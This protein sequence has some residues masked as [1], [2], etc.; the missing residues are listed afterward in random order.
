MKYISDNSLKK[1]VSK[2]GL[3]TGKFGTIIPDDFAFEMLD[4]FIDYGGTVIDTARNYYEWVENGR[5]KSEE[6][7]GKWIESRHLREKICIVTK[8]GVRNNYKEW[9]IDLSKNNLVQELKESLDSLRTDYIDIYLLHRDERE[10]SVEEIMDTMQVLNDMGHIRMIGVANW[11]VERIRSANEYAKKHGLKPFKILQTWWSVAD[12][13]KEMWND[14]NTTCMDEKTYQY[15][16]DQNMIGMAY[17]S[18]CKGYFQKAAQCGKDGVDAFLRERIETK[19]NLRILD[20][21][22]RYSKEKNIDMTSLVSGYVTS[23]RVPGIALVSCSTMEQLWDI[24][25]HCD[26]QMPNEVID[27]IRSIKGE[28]HE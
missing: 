17:T 15:M 21:L 20:Y 16:L 13:K 24:V 28:D 19:K 8:C 6:C 11:N 14:K 27:N 18:Q 4:R 26:Y 9:M 12:Y 7:I 3:G 1:K 25:Q 2:I 5:G 10:R 22:I 23:G